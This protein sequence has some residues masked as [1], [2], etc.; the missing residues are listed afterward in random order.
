MI[1]EELLH[2]I[3]VHFPLVMFTLAMIIKALEIS[4]FKWKKQLRENYSFCVKVLLFT[5]PMLYIISMFLGDSA[6]EIITKDICDLTAAYRHESLSY[7]AMYA[8][9]VALIFETLTVIDRFTCKLLA[10]FHF[11]VLTF[12]IVGNVYM[13]QSAHSGAM[14][15]YEQ[16]AAVKNAVCK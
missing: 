5:A 6:L 12:L 9:C 13:F 11:L 2:P 3:S 16:G 15:V 4:S 1:R 10:S 14:L 7:N 8:F